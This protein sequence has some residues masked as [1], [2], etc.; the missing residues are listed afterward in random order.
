[1]RTQVHLV[2]GMVNGM[3]LRFIDT[4]GLE[5]GAAGVGHNVR[6]LTVARRA[7]K[8]YKADLVLYVDRLDMVLLCSPFLHLEDPALVL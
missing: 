7:H 1:M 2:T 5:P 8:K 4:P 6:A 3:E